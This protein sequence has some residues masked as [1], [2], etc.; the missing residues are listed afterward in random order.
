MENI[1]ALI[2]KFKLS[3]RFEYK[4]LSSK[5]DRD[6][7]LKNELYQN[8]TDLNKDRTTRDRLNW[9]IKDN[10]WKEGICGCCKINPKSFLKVAC[11]NKS[12]LASE[13]QKIVHKNFSR[14]K[15]EEIRKN[16]ENTYLKKYGV[17]HNFLIPKVIEDRKNTW[18]K[19]YGEDNPNKSQIV[20]DKIIKTNNDRWGGN[21]PMSND[22]IK[23]KSIETLRKTFNNL[24]IVNNSQLK[25][26]QEK[27]RLNSI[28]KWGF[29][30]H[31][32]NP[33]FRNT[34]FEKYFTKVPYYSG[35]N[36]RE[37]D[38][39]GVILKLQGYEPQV[40][41]YLTEIYPNNEILGGP[42][43]MIQYKFNYYDTQEKRWRYYLP[44]LYDLTRN[45]II[46]VKSPY[47]LGNGR[48]T[49]DKKNE[50]IKNG[51]NFELVIRD[52]NEKITIKRY[53]FIKS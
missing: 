37:Y 51:F 40:L 18:I 16:K 23:N 24:D 3:K 39:K 15:K 8:T 13:S 47:T 32:K 31:M 50:V 45:T 33:E 26:I 48:N 7:N 44:D 12:C 17:K 25:E 36:Y 34:F 27:K 11:D 5:I 21:S 49:L 19:N 1:K 38:H 35:G 41:K 14:D 6:E 30:N 2:E 22:L 53:E 52:K 46:E 42:K 29:D 4:I 43:D 9:V 28:N 10:N 20:K